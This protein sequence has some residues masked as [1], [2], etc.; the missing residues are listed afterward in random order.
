[1]WHD[2]VIKNKL[3]VRAVIAIL[4][5]WRSA[6]DCKSHNNSFVNSMYCYISFTR[7]HNDYYDITLVGLFVIYSGV[8]I[9]S[10]FG[11]IHVF[12][13]PLPL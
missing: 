10:S 7:K 2:I 9:L 12:E 13:Q 3:N 8:Y 4:G 11:P 1:M 6:N 5:R